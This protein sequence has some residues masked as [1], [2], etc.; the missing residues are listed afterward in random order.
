M[1]V[2]EGLFSSVCFESFISYF[3]LF[4]PTASMGSHNKTCFFH[5]LNASFNVWSLLC[6]YLLSRLKNS[7][8]SLY[9]NFVNFD[10]FFILFCILS[11]Y[12]SLF[13]W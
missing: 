2:F 4:L 9:R 13:L 3:P 6:P 7:A 5:T 8:H 1:D 10:P 12:I 11:N